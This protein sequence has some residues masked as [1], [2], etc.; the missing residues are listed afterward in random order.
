MSLLARAT[1]VTPGSVVVAST[2]RHPEP[3]R[4]F[5]IVGGQWVNE[6]GVHARTIDLLFLAVISDADPNAEV[7]R[8]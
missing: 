3:T 4:W 1:P 5:A 2:S 6:A 8:R 7:N